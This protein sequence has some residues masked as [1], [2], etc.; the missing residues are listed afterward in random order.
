MDTT[1]GI[2]SAFSYGRKLVGAGIN[3]IREGTAAA[4]SGQSI[5]TVTSDTA[6]RSIC[7]AIAGAC[8]GIAGA[9]LLGT[10]RQRDKVAYG[11]LGAGVGF[12]AGVLWNTR[13]QTSTVARAALKEIRNVSD[14]HWLE[15]NPIDYA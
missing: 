15:S 6:S 4:L 3:G 12:L 11:A 8:L 2:G 5:R 13:S 14:E 1:E 7:I 10:K 9:S